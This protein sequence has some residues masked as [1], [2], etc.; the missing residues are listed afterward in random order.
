MQIKQTPYQKLVDATLF[1]GEF[2]DRLFADGVKPYEKDRY[3]FERASHILHDPTGKTIVEIGMYPGTGVYYFG[4]HNRIIG[5]GKT[6]PD[7]S[8]KVTETGHIIIDIDL[9][10]DDLP[11]EYYGTADI[12]L[13]MEVIEHIRQPKLFLKKIAKMLGGGGTIYNDEQQ[14]VYWLSSKTYGF[15]AYP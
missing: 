14:F 11:K 1:G 2:K 12:M 3:R 10:K 4:E 5:I 6:T 13:C 8:T 9:E 15:K 7:F